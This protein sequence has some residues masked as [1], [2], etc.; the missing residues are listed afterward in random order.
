MMDHL[1]TAYD[2]E[3]FDSIWQ[4]VMPNTS[5]QITPTSQVGKNSDDESQLRKFIDDESADCNYYAM[6]AQKCL[7]RS[8]KQLFLRLSTEEHC[9]MKRLQTAYF[10]LTG[11]SYYPAMV[12]PL[13]NSIMDSL[14]ARYIGETE[15]AEAYLKAAG[16]TESEKLACIYRELAEDENRHACSIE[17]LIEMMMR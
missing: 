15:G 1:E 9:H 3:K 14:R 16:E 2:R 13:I 12:C 8:I 6:L 11:D 7:S 17:T 4:R 5:E 10:I